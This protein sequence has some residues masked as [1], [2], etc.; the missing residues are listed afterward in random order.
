MK[1]LRILLLLLCLSAAGFA[2]SAQSNIRI[3]CHSTIDSTNRPLYVIVFKKKKVRFLANKAA[4]SLKSILNMDYIDKLSVFKDHSATAL[5]GARA[6]HGV[7]VINIKKEFAKKA[8]R[9]L[10]QYLD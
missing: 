1:N 4:D 8:Y 3:V 10:E 6:Q 9:Q 5:Y 7:L 2:A